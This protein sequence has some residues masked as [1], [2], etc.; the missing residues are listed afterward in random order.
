MQGIDESFGETAYTVKP[1]AYWTPSA[2][3]VL[4]YAVEPSQAQP[5]DP[6]TW[7]QLKYGSKPDL[8]LNLPRLYDFEEQ[9]GISS[10]A[11]RFISPGVEVLKAGCGSS[12]PGCTSPCAEP[13]PLSQGSAATGESL[14]LRAQVQNY[15][16][17]DQTGLSTVQFYDA[18]PDVGGVPIG[19]PVLV[20]PVTARDSQRRRD[21]VDAGRALRRL[22]AADLRRRRVR[23]RHRRAPRGQQQGIPQLP[24]GWRTRRSRSMPPRT[25][26]PNPPPGGRS[27]S[28]GTSRTRSRRSP[29]TTGSSAPIRSRA[30][31][32]SRP[33]LGATSVGRRSRTCL[34]IATGSPSSRSGAASP[35]RHRIRPSR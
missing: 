34:R 15:S 12:D 11:A 16:L 5:G 9:A 13:Q 24:G 6:K 19:S 22:A 32:P 25:S 18:D 4:D 28:P 21:R 8:T 35:R 1:F 31:R 33:R 3:L 10:D 7:W 17:K 30:G 2:T 27:T 23:R 29:R 20:N 26:S 14:C